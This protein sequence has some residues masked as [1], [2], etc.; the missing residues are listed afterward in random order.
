MKK[1]CAAGSKCTFEGCKS[2]EDCVCSEGFY[3]TKGDCK[4]C[5]VDHFCPGG[6]KS[7]AC[8]PNS[9]APEGAGNCACMAGFTSYGGNCWPEAAQLKPALKTTDWNDAGCVPPPTTQGAVLT[10]PLADIVCRHPA[11]LMTSATSW[12]GKFLDVSGNGRVGTLRGGAVSSGTVNGNGAGRPIA[13]VGGNVNTG[14]SFGQ[15]S[16]PSTFTI[17]SITRYTGPTKKRILYC[18]NQNWLHGHWEGKAG[19]THYNSDKAGNL[20]YSI[21]T[22]TD[23]VVACGRNIQTTGSAGVIINGVVT[24]FGSADMKGG[25]NC[26][27]AINMGSTYMGDERSDWQ[28]SKLYVWN[29]HLPDA[30][31][32]DVEARLNKFLTAAGSPP[33]PRPWNTINYLDR[34]DVD[35]KGLPMS[36]FQM[37]YQ[38]NTQI[39]WNF[40]T[41]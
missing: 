13:Y 25:G 7:F 30:V 15:A 3:G 22:S 20:Q 18:Y 17:C 10:D 40:M 39:R 23:W 36:S 29:T 6:D 14:I 5:P 9:K 32:A 4:T 21:R 33:P 26:E 2:Q 1:S 37:N 35:C 27:L 8:P 12:D 24:A 16:I 31:F 41:S 28:L 19:S 38:D 34:Q 11:Y